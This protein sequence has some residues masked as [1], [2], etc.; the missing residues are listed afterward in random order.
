ML[1]RNRKSWQK[2]QPENEWAPEVVQKKSPNCLTK[3]KMKFSLKTLDDYIKENKRQWESMQCGN[4]PLA[5]RCTLWY[6]LWRYSQPR[7]Q[8]Q[9]HKAKA[10]RT[11]TMIMMKK[12]KSG[13]M[14]SKMLLYSLHLLN[15]EPYLKA[16]I[17]L[18]ATLAASLPQCL[19]VTRST[20]SRIATKAQ[21][22]FWKGKGLFF[23]VRRKEAAYLFIVTLHVCVQAWGQIVNACLNVVHLHCHAQRT[24]GCIEKTA[25]DRTS[26]KHG[27]H[28]KHEQ[29]LHSWWL[30]G[31]K[32]NCETF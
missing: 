3:R 7:R 28:G 19:R 32:D 1:A 8:Q 30:I 27:K 4:C 11:K 15:F 24:S 13:S 21:Q 29:Y 26:E 16:D 31:E 14:Q 25:T 2:T 12:R 23:V 22:I 6:P 17:R 10:A 20:Q 5:Q 18:S 9:Q